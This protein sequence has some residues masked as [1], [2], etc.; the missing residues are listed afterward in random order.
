MFLFVCLMR[1][2]VVETTMTLDTRLAHRDKPEEK[3]TEV[4]KSTE[5]RP[6][7]CKTT[8]VRIHVLTIYRVILCK[9]SLLPHYYIIIICFVYEFCVQFNYL[10]P[11]VSVWVS[12]LRLLFAHMVLYDVD[13]VITTP[14]WREFIKVNMICYFYHR[15]PTTIMNTTAT[16]YLCL[17]WAVCTPVSTSSTFACR[18]VPL[19]MGISTRD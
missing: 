10:R 8:A 3:W 5:V 12:E 6:L 18:R 4:A 15:I 17:S 7:N 13:H 19:T 2:L 16:W 11:L 1:M 14:S 9:T